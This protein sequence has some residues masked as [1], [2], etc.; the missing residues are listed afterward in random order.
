MSVV[1]VFEIVLLSLVLIVLLYMSL[2]LAIHIIF[3]R[4][5]IHYI[6]LMWIKITPKEVINTKKL[7]VG[8]VVRVRKDLK[9]RSTIGDCYVNKS[10]AS[11]ARK[12]VTIKE[13]KTYGNVYIEESDWYFRSEMFVQPQLNAE[14]AFEAMVRGQISE[15][16]YEEVIRRERGRKWYSRLVKR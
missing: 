2:D 16:E 7:N 15:S 14:E 8:D 10:M 11:L 5:L 12:K 6:D 3:S 13:V 1:T 9:R 4:P